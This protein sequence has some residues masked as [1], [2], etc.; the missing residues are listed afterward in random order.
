[1]NNYL[2]N[3]DKS[4]IS[5]YHLLDFIRSITLINMIL[6]HGLY[7]L[8]YL[9]QVPIPL[10]QGNAGY[11]WQ[12][13]I[14]WTFIF[15]SGISFHFGKHHLKNGM[16]LS[17][18]G[19]IITMI[20]YYATPD[21]PVYMGILSFMGLA[22]L[23]MIPL[24]KMLQKISPL[25]GVFFSLSFF[26]LTRGV[27][28]GYLGFEALNLIELPNFLYQFK[29]GFVF[30]FPLPD[31]VSGDYFSLFPWFFLYVSGY[32]VW[33]LVKKSSKV[34]DFAK[35]GKLSPLCFIG[36]HTLPIYMIHQPLLLLLLEFIFM[37]K[38]KF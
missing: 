12:Q 15:L 9:F 30:G 29:W 31:F 18:F 1:M 16:I 38:S 26:F 24:E 28:Q 25:V 21:L 2:F 37:I 10:Y 8:V 20:T 36:R 27:N 23:L 33:S 32:F 14:C 4:S 7:D 22:G 35:L 13:A 34:L 6:Y 17:L 5:R 3:R 19:L 11:F